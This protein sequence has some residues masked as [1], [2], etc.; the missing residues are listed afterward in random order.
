LLQVLQNCT[1]EDSQGALRCAQLKLVTL[2]TL[3]QVYFVTEDK[4]AE[5]MAAAAYNMGR[6]MKSE[7][8][9]WFTSR[10]ILGMSISSLFAKE[11]LFWPIHSSII[12]RYHLH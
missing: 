4:Q 6:K 10:T 3:A 12:I 9:C 2:A 5:K 1:A 7:V 8:A 11:V